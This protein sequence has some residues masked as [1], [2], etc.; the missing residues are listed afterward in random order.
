[1]TRAT[2][3]MAAVLCLALVSLAA[4]S[5]Q[6]TT[7]TET[8]LFEIVSVD[9]NRVV[10]KGDKGAQ[11]IT[12]PPDF[13]LTVEGKPVTVAELKPGM[14]GTATI[15]TTTTVTP[16]HVTEVR[17]G[18]VVQKAGNSIIVR[19]D[20]GLQMF[21]EGDVTKRGIKIIRD[22][23][24]VTIAELRQG[25]RLSATIVTEMPP[26][27]VTERDVAAAMSSAPARSGAAA[28]TTAAAPGAAA[29]G[30]T[31]AASGARLPSTASPLPLIGLF[32]AASIALGL[33]LTARRRR[34]GA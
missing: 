28:A 25:D 6:Q 29:P 12:V 21:S 3:W 23:R 22:G 19:G 31:S 33:V 17:N 34:G 26:K 13:R 15:T 5:A 9:G 30:G 18:E 27:V 1:M 24:P 8:R 32:G 7:S 4:A 14:K 16:V 20:K 10:V 2:H 11:E